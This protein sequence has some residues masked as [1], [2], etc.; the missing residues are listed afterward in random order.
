[1][2]HLN[3]HGRYY[4]HMY[5][6]HTSPPGAQPRCCNPTPAPSISKSH[7]L[8]LLF[9]TLLNA[10]C[11]APWVGC[12]SGLLGGVLVTRPH[13]RLCCQDIQPRCSAWHHTWGSSS[14]PAS[15][16]SV[17]FRGLSSAHGLEAAGLRCWWPQPSPAQCCE[18]INFPFWMHLSPA[19][20][21][22]RKIA[23]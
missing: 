16:P 8:Q 18:S 17:P 6:Q 2:L 9:L 21:A 13:S 11:A 7:H 12:P 23:V 3:L 19:C 20:L 14:S 15:H 10:S 1:M 4:C 22:V 5:L